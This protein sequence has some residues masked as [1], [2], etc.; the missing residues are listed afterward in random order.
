MFPGTPPVRAESVDAIRARWAAV[1]ECDP[2]TLCGGGIIVTSWNNDDVEFLFM[3]E[4]TA[5]AAP[6]DLASRLRKSLDE[7]SLECST[8]QVRTIVA[9]LAT[10][11]GVHGPQFVGYA[12]RTTF[13]PVDRRTTLADPSAVASLRAT[14]SVEEWEQSG[15]RVDATPVTIVAP[16]E[17]EVHTAAQYEIVN[18]IAS[19]CVLSH[20]AHRGGGY[21]KAVVSASTIH[22][23]DRG[24]V[25]E[26]RTLEEWPSSVGLARD[27][28]YKR[29]AQSLLVRTA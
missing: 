2:A 16:S 27:L 21:A 23:L 29:A 15:L 10:V 5:I 9:R 7:S 14:C 26:Y 17:R 12:D 22:A 8:S 25:A 6:P 13:D 11:D 1:M 18:G 24:F 28:G 4:G 20:P 3:E 19:M